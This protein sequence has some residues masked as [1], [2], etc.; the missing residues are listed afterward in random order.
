MRDAPPTEH[1]FSF[2][3]DANAGAGY[4]TL[5]KKFSGGDYTTVGTFPYF[6]DDDAFE[7]EDLDDSESINDEKQNSSKE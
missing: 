4:G 1:R 5:K 2:K 7:D 6:E 3:G